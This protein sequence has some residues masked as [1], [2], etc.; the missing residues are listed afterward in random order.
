MIKLINIHELRA[1]LITTWPEQKIIKLQ[2]SPHYAYLCG[3]KQ[4]YIDYL[5]KANQ[6]EH[7]VEKFDK[8][9]ETFVLRSTDWIQCREQ[10]GVYIISDGFHRACIF[11]HRGITG[12]IINQIN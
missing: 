11:L 3:D 5:K 12:I 8:L 2:D 4:P 6:E 9:I 7:S 1:R 10:D